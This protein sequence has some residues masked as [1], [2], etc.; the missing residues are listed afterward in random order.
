VKIFNGYG[1]A[2]MNFLQKKSGSEEMLKIQT[3]FREAKKISM[4]NINH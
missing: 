4:L 3:I 1:Q 2:D